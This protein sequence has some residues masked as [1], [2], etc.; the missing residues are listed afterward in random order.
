MISQGVD[1]VKF[2]GKA[3]QYPGG[4]YSAEPISIA[5]HLYFLEAKVT[6]ELSK[7]ATGIFCFITPG[8]ITTANPV[9]FCNGVSR[10]ALGY[11]NG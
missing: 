11:I 4:L 2:T 8:P 10:V 3:P 7:A 1:P 9:M 6:A 5:Q